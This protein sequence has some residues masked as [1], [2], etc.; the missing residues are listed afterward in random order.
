MELAQSSNEELSLQTYWF[1][2][3][4]ERLCLCIQ[5]AR[6]RSRIVSDVFILFFMTP[7]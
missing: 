6:Y 7:E 2:W 5:D 1:C 4:H 3:V